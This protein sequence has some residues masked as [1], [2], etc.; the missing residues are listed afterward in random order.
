MHNKHLTWS[1]SLSLKIV[2]WGREK[3]SF[4][5]AGASAVEKHLPHWMG[6]EN[7]LIYINN[8]I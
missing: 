3:L 2:S 8:H 5:V 1:T 6:I 7:V 4:I